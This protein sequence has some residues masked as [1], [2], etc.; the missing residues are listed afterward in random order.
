M[1]DIS[2]Q[3]RIVGSV[4]ICEIFDG[5]QVALVRPTH[6][7]AEKE[8]VR[9]NVWA[10]MSGYPLHAILKVNVVGLN[11]RC[12]VQAKSG[13]GLYAHSHGEDVNRSWQQSNLGAC[14]GCSSEDAKL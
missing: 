7:A 3:L 6:E 8:V 5:Y 4:A 14:D 10:L 12:R 11:S 13:I 1:E 9:K 2:Q